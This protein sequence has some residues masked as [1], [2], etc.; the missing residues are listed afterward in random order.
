MGTGQRMNGKQ[1][2]MRPLAGGGELTKDNERLLGRIRL[3]LGLRVPVLVDAVA[4]VCDAGKGREISESPSP[5]QRP[6]PRLLRWGG[7]GGVVGDAAPE[8]P[9]DRALCA[10]KDGPCANGAARSL[11]EESRCVLRLPQQRGA[12]LGHRELAQSS[13]LRRHGS[14]GERAVGDCGRGRPWRGEERRW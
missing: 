5:P 9:R 14:I 1:V 10:A 8:L 13:R 7:R 12:R 4:N 6:E 11:E 2:G 3:D